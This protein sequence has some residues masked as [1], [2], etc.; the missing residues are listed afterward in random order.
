[1]ILRVMRFEQDK[2]RQYLVQ[3]LQDEKFTPFLTEFCL[4][5]MGR[6]LSLGI[7]LSIL[8]L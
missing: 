4:R 5:H 1:M 2:M 3:C 8:S 7:V 6:A